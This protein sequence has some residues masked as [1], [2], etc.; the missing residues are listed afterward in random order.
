MTRRDSAH[1]G[2]A[3]PEPRGGRHRRGRPG[4]AR[5]R[6]CRASRPSGGSRPARRGPT[7]FCAGASMARSIHAIRTIASSRISTLRRAM[8]AAR[9]EYVATFALA[10]PIDLRKSSQRADLSGRQPRQW[11]RVSP[12]RRW[13]HRAGQRMA[14]R[15][16]PDGQQLDDCRPDR[17]A[18]DGSPDHWSGDCAVLRRSCRHSHTRNPSELDGHRTAPIPAGHSRPDE[19]HADDVCVGESRRC[20]HRNNRRSS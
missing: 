11:R 7:I 4:H 10:R 13:G 9:V 14:G 17:E 6:S 20:P 18:A 8:R 15:R 5:S 1:G 3:A 12:N 16:R 2:A 19:R